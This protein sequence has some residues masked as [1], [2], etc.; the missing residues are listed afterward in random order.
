MLASPKPSEARKLESFDYVLDNYIFPGVEMLHDLLKGSKLP[1]DLLKSHF[2]SLLDLVTSANINEV[3]KSLAYDA[4]DEDLQKSIKTIL[5]GDNKP[6]LKD[7]YEPLYCLL[8][9]YVLNKSP[10]KQRD[11]DNNALVAQ[12]I[13]LEGLSREA[14]Y[15]ETVPLLGTLL[16]RMQKYDPEVTTDI[17]RRRVVDAIKTAKDKI[18]AAPEKEE[19]VVD[20]LKSATTFVPA[21]K[22][23]VLL[24][25][26]QEIQDAIFAEELAKQLEEEDNLQ[27]ALAIQAQDSDNDDD[28]HDNDVEDDDEDELEQV[29]AGAAQ[30]GA[31][32]ND[33]EEEEEEDD[34]S[35]SDEQPKVR[36]STP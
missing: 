2:I 34:A 20:P 16:S 11:I 33:A 12:R 35:L 14:L 32:H 13:E 17:L 18:L 4:E 31:G 22:D 24:K 15:E 30:A 6:L 21:Y 19:E 26:R 5:G 25:R 27:A 23:P 36:R 10:D 7:V 29:G 8:H 28:N 9:Q 1:A 3:S